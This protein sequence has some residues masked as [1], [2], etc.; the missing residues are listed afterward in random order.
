M[1]IIGRIGRSLFIRSSI[2]RSLSSS[3]STPVSLAVEHHEF[4]NLVGNHGE[5]TIE[6]NTI[7]KKLGEIVINNPTRRN[8]ISG[9]MMLDL[10]NII[11]QLL[12]ES[13]N[14]DKP[15]ALILRN[16]GASVFCRLSLS[17]SSSSS[18]S[19]TSSS[20]PLL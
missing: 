8:A 7:G 1:V 4:L 19:S 17:T 15:L 6:Y 13:N 16:E 9:T 5:G 11:D 18:L 2:G 14:D 10:A 12:M 20:S 3:S